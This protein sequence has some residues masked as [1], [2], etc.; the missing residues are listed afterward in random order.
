MF[1]SLDANF[2]LCRR[3]NAAR[4]CQDAPLLPNFFMNQKSVDSLVQHYDISSYSSSVSIK[5]IVVMC[6]IVPINNRI[7][8]LVVSFVLEM[9]CAHRVVS[10]L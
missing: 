3:K 8:N 6:I 10:R 4:C 7:L 1:V 9:P 5:V 2:R